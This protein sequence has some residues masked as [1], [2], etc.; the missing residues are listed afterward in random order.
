MS[1]GVVVRAKDVPAA[2]GLA[3]AEFPKKS[4][5]DRRPY[6]T[7]DEKESSWKKPG[8]AAGPFEASSATA[9]W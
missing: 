4:G 7:P 2:T 3:R 1:D 8:P 6:V 5:P 9:A